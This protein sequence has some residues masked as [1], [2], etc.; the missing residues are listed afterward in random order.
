MDGGKFTKEIIPVEIPHP[1]GE[2]Q[3]VAEDEE[4]R[5]VDFDKLSTL[6]PAFEEGGTVTAGN[7]S[8]ISDG[9]AAVVLAAEDVAQRRGWKPLARILGQA[10]AAMA[11]AWV[12]IAPA[13]ATQLLLVEDGLRQE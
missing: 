1:K 8:S 12:T 4:P 6:R 3:V 7:A 2:P 10:G 5:R 11:P 9:A 13:Q